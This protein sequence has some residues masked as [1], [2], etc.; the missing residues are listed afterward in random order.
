MNCN[1]CS[2][3]FNTFKELTEHLIK[4]HNMSAQEVYNYFG[5]S[6]ESRKAICPICGSSFKITPKQAWK[7]KSN[8]NISLG[9]CK[10]CSLQIRSLTHESP[11]ARKEVCRL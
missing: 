4:E 3:K 6:M 7:Y 5:Y 2:K 1:I 9:C 8:P 10:S 11:F